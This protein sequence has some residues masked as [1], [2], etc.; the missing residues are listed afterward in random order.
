MCIISFHPLQSSWTEGWKFD[1]HPVSA[2]SI[3]AFFFPRL[4]IFAIEPKPSPFIAKLIK[5]KPG[6][7]YCF[8]GDI[9]PLIPSP[10][11]GRFLISS[12]LGA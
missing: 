2:P 9:S 12:S 7:F 3:P 6:E 8:N 10:R 4:T 1:I 11:P 5:T